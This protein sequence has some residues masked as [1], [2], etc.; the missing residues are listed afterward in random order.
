MENN[1]QYRHW[2]AENIAKT[3]L[4]E[5][6][7]LDV[8]QNEDQRFDFV[9]M[10]KSNLRNI[11]AVQ[12]KASQYNKSEITRLYRKDRQ[13]NLN[14]DIPILM[15]YINHIDKTGY[16][17]F[18]FKILSDELKVLNTDSLKN[19]IRNFRFDVVR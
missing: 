18:I 4:Y 11:F 19:E 17:E 8:Y 12:I 3:Y 5:T 6:G 14:Y 2:M 15:L 1:N 7:M 10:L 16:F 9:C 13:Q